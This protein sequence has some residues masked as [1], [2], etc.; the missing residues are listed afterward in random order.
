MTRWSSSS[1]PGELPLWLNLGTQCNARQCRRQTAPSLPELSFLCPDTRDSAKGVIC[2]Q[3]LSCN[4]LPPISKY[5][6][7]T[8]RTDVRPLHLNVFSL[9]HNESNPSPDHDCGLDN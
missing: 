4:T 7:L 5:E 2:R 3:I 1:G 9:K 6:D 8:T